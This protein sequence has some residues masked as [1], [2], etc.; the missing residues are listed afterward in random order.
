M[1]LKQSMPEKVNQLHRSATSWY[2]S[3]DWMSE[4]VQ[5]SID[6]LDFE[7]AADL[8]EQHTVTLFSQGKL[9]QLV[10]WIHRLPAGISTR[11]P[12]LSIHQ[13]WALAFAGKTSEAESLRQS[14][15]ASMEQTDLSPRE[16]KYLWAEIHTLAGVLAVMSGNHQD[17]LTLAEIL[18]TAI[19]P[20][21]PFV[22]SG[23]FWALGY[24]WRM[25]GNLEKAAGSFREM[26]AAGRQI[27]NLWT[28]ATAFADLGMV[29]RLSGRLR[30]AEN[31][32][33][34]GLQIMQQNGAN[35]LGFVGRLES[36]LAHILYEEDKLDQAEQLIAKSI[37]H[38]QLW[39]NPN[40]L[41]HAY[42][43]Q[44]RILY[45]S[46]DTTWDYALKKAEEIVTHEAVVP[47]LR[48]GI[49][50][51]RAR[52]WLAQGQ[53]DE[54]DRWMELQLG[55]EG[56]RPSNVEVLDAQ[57]MAYAR[58]CIAQGKFPAAWKLLQEVESSARA[59]SRKNTLVEA[60]LLK[61]RAASNRATAVENVE[62]ALALGIPEGYRRVFLDEGETL[63]PFLE[64]LRDRSALVEPL[65][66]ARTKK[67]KAAGLLTAREL[68]ILR[69]MAEGL[70][71][72]EIGQGLFI[73]AGT[74]KAHSA[75]IYRKLEVANRT[76]AIARAKDL[77]LL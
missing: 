76:A 31:V 25:E 73:S 4:A 65:I 69:G 49:E 68:D 17:A 16:Q 67:S 9:D 38:N 22:R 59:G 66:G 52:F 35:G 57:R 18:D 36:F 48:A 20:D 19:P 40:H 44:A 7:R 58:I 53:V 8:V 63:I 2:E 54:A 3:K 32:Y 47:S 60:L 29:L 71:N 64:S 13:A 45:A 43:T 23:A 11:R 10:G 33:R 12:S 61:A 51:L 24:A 70:S 1:R 14:A 26:L 50:A 56:S 77:R 75:A 15:I 34:A 28:Q 46:G 55:L 6:G 21:S 72:K 41:A 27:D 37:A 5:H 39:N 62:A 42:W 74:V 30:E